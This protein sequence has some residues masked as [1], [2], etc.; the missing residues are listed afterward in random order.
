MNYQLITPLLGCLRLL[1]VALL[2]CSLGLWLEL[3]WFA[4]ID[5]SDRFWRFSEVRLLFALAGTLLTCAGYWWIQR[6]QQ[7]SKRGASHDHV[8]WFFALAAFIGAISGLGL[9]ELISTLAAHSEV[10]DLMHFLERQ[11]FFFN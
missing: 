5:S 11:L 10:A 3:L 4:A 1:L 8:P 2:L 7:P 9:W 6:R